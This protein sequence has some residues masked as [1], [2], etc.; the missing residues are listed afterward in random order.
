MNTEEAIAAGHALAYKRNTIGWGIGAFFFPLIVLPV[1]HFSSPNMPV[2]EATK[3]DSQVQPIYERAYVE[4]LKK[5]QV[6][7]AWAGAVVPMLLWQL[8][9]YMFIVRLGSSL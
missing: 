2:E 4:D 9:I 1:A 5:R 3:I 8:L 7:T 6:K